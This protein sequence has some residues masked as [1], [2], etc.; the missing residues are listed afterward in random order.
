MGLGVYRFWSEMNEFREMRDIIN[1][2]EL[3]YYLE[4]ASAHLWHGHD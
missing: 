4:P 2:L 3:E 1:S